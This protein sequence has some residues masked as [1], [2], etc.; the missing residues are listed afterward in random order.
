MTGK[1]LQKILPQANYVSSKQWDLRNPYDVEELFYGYK[2]DCVIHLA[3][4][5]GG[6]FDNMKKPAEYFDDNV[7]INTNVL[8]ASKKYGVDRLIAMLSTCAYPDIAPS[9]PMKEEDIHLGPPA[10]TNIS[11][12]YS[13]RALSIQI[14]AYNKQYE[15]KYQYLIPS[16]LYGP[17]DKFGENSHFIAALIKKIH[18][19]KI[20]G[21]KKIIL[22]GDGTPLRQFMHSDDLAYII[23]YC[24]ENDIYEH[25]NVAS[26]E[27]LS[28]KDMAIIALKAMGSEDFV[29]EFDTTKPNGQF[30]KDVSTEKLRKFIPDFKPY[31]LYEGITKTYN[32]VNKR[33]LED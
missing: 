2:P 16:N 15:T 27:N 25:M 14:D 5:A 31:G 23:K 11:Y 13:K 3:A 18:Q 4:K 8:R 28:I 17:N 33:L 26:D 6:I 32:E 29:V 20:R 9:Y 30:R 19:A 7:L 21:E 12:G 22:F 1:S 24:L 10:P